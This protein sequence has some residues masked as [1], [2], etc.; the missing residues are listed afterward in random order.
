MARSSKNQFVLKIEASPTSSAE[1]MIKVTCNNTFSAKLKKREL[2]PDDFKK[3]V[4]S[5]FK[6]L[7]LEQLSP[8]EIS[9]L[10]IGPFPK[11]MPSELTS[12]HMIDFFNDIDLHLKRDLVPSYTDMKDYWGESFDDK[13]A[14]KKVKK[15]SRP[16]DSTD[17]LGTYIG[18]HSLL[19]EEMQKF[20]GFYWRFTTQ[21][22]INFLR[23][24]A[25]NS[26]YID[27]AQFCEAMEKCV[28]AALN[29]PRIH[30]LTRSGS[31]SSTLRI[32]DTK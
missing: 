13:L 27:K 7:K 22:S 29:P 14:D 30:Y 9:E 21:D 12:D 24:C 23:E 25:G 32:P 3:E 10:L 1:G 8:R 16:G 28:R 5:V 11:G 4:V 19:S 26:D 2:T 15:E 17:K 18:A 31:R 6:K 20:G